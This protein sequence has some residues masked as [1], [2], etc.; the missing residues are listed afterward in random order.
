A[1]R[2]GIREDNTEFANGGVSVRGAQRGIAT[3]HFAHPTC[4]K[5]F[6]EERS[7]SNL[8][9]ARHVVLVSKQNFQ[10]HQIMSMLKEV[11]AGVT[12]CARGR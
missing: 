6:L 8:G 12:S 5:L 1:W 10:P 9:C 2:A 7:L 11:L 3:G 4:G